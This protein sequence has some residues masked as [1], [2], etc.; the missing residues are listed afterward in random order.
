MASSVTFT[1]ASKAAVGVEA[2]VEK[3]RIS[4]PINFF[5]PFGSDDE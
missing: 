3:P 4:V 5:Y 2:A 1:D